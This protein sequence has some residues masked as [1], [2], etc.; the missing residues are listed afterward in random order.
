M[1]LT[2]EMMELFMLF[3]TTYFPLKMI[4]GSNFIVASCIINEK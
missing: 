2:V 3:Y 4:D 1:Y